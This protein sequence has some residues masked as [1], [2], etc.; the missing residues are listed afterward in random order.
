MKYT[1]SGSIDIRVSATPEAVEVTVEDEG[2]GIP[3][4]QL[5]RIFE[6]FR[7]VQSPNTRTSGGTGLGLSVTRRL[8][9]LMGGS[10]SVRS[11]PDEGSTF[12]VRIPVRAPEGHAGTR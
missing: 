8:V 1:E 3:E 10:I 5:E 7:Q 2:I 11:R 9:E 4:D 6:P 12:T